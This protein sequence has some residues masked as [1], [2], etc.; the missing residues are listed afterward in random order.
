MVRILTIYA[1]A[2]SFLVVPA[3]C[4]GGVITHACECDSEI[5]RTGDADCGH[6]TGCGHE[7]ACPEDPCGIEVL[8]PEHHGD[9]IVTISQPAGSTTI[10]LIAVT[11]SSVQTKHAG[12]EEW[13]GGKKLPFPPSDLPLL[14]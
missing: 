1:V 11:Q 5:E 8:R 2:A 6:E 13:P 12:T 7:G 10:L 3:L 4:M 14:I 9:D